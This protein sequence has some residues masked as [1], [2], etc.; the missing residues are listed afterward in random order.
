MGGTVQ[1]EA[2]ETQ[3]PSADAENGMAEYQV[4]G[5]LKDPE[6]KK[7]DWVSEIIKV[8]KISLSHTHTHTCTVSLLYAITIGQ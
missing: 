3:N 6:T 7:A 2:E 4:V 8:R 1:E 5:T